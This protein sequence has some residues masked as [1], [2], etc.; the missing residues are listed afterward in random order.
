MQFGLV[1]HAVLAQGEQDVL[2]DA[3]GE[4][5]GLLEHHADSTAQQL[6]IHAA[7]Q[8][9]LAIDQYLAA[10]P[11]AGHQIAHA[12]DRRQQA[13]LAAT[14]GADQRHQL[15]GGHVEGGAEQGPLLAIMHA[16]SLDAQ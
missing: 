5:V 13:A 1:A 6:D 10:D 16:E 2:G 4:G 7:A 11:G 12:V 3:Q 15:A 8:H 14:A 9:V